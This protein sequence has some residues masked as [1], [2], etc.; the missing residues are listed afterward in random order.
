LLYFRICRTS[1]IIIILVYYLAEALLC[2]KK[3]NTSNGE[4]DKGQ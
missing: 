2:H 4:R 3:Q 1:V